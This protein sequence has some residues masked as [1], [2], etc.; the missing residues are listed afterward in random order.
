M[1]CFSLSKTLSSRTSW[2][3]GAWVLGCLDA[4][5]LVFIVFFFFFSFEGVWK[6]VACVAS[7]VYPKKKLSTVSSCFCPCFFPPR[8]GLFGIRKT[9]FLTLHHKKRPCSS[10]EMRVGWPWPHSPI[11][12]WILE[13]VAYIHT[14]VL[15][16]LLFPHMVSGIHV[17]QYINSSNRPSRTTT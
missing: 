13:R 16:D 17:R 5:G 4:W 8:F 14:A 15:H 1:L 2:C 11:H 12:I 10:K 6:D 9:C 3:L 7:R